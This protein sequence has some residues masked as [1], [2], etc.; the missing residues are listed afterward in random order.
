MRDV[1]LGLIV[2]LLVALNVQ[3]YVAFVHQPTE[4]KVVYV[5]PPDVEMSD[6]E[7]VREMDKYDAANSQPESAPAPQ[8]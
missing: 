7:L 4:K 8:P 1:F 5:S 6:E 2:A 3:F